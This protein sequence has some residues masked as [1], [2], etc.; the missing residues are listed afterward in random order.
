M[1]TFALLETLWQDAGYGVRTLRKSP[2]FLAAVVLSL[3][4]GIGANSTFFSVLNAVMYRPLPY[5]QPD[6]LMVIWEI[7]TGRPAAERQTPAIADAA[8]WRKQSHV[9]EDIALTSGVEPTPMSAAGVTEQGRAQ[10]VAPNF[11]HLLRVSPMMGRVFTASDAQDLTQTVILSY[12]FW[13]RRFHSDPKVLGQSFKISG[14]LSTVVG[15]MPPSFGALYGDP[16][17]MW[18]PISADSARYSERK[19]HWLHAF[20]RL[21]PGATQTQAQTEMNVIAHRLEQAY[22]A[23]NKGVGARVQPCRYKIG[24]GAA[25]GRYCGSR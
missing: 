25:I 14:V 18:V 20:G 4:P 16:L 10:F 12:A 2:A 23:T 8:D 13:K 9:F 6:R 11:F 5:W 17:D 24:M 15:V 1:R 21:K 22:P 3:A 7:E 19:D